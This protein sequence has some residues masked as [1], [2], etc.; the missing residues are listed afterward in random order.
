MIIYLPLLLSLPPNALGL[1][2]ARAAALSN[3]S[4]LNAFPEFKCVDRPSWSTANYWQDG[5]R[6]AWDY[7]RATEAPWAS[8]SFEFLPDN[9]LPEFR[10]R[11]KMRTPRRYN[12]GR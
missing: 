5:C 2:V 4:S 1:A 11:D 10:W 9:V 6:E 7:A 8:T 3:A 12:K